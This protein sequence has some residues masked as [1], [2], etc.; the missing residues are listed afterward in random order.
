MLKARD[1]PF[2]IH[3]DR[4]ELLSPQERQE[5]RSYNKTYGFLKD[6]TSFSNSQHKYFFVKTLHHLFTHNPSKV[7]SSSFLELIK[8]WL[9]IILAHFE[10]GYF[11]ENDLIHVLQHMKTALTH[12]NRINYIHF[13]SFLYSFIRMFLKQCLFILVD[14]V[15]TIGVQKRSKAL[16][17]IEQLTKNSHDPSRGLNFGRHPL[18]HQEK[19]WSS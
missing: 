13:S 8:K 14:K 9:S 18:T 19:C 6:D 5:I 7:T 16:A 15:Y 2:L 3:S 4:V 17:A 10:F 1:T 11:D 12:M